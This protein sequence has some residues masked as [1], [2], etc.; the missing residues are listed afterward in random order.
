MAD[1]KK[2]DEKPA[3]NIKSNSPADFKGTDKDVDKSKDKNPD[4]DKGSQQPVPDKV[5]PTKP[6]AAEG[7]KTVEQ[8]KEGAP[9]E[10]PPAEKAAEKSGGEAPDQAPPPDT[11]APDPVPEAGSEATKDEAAG[12]PDDSTPSGSHKI[13]IEGEGQ[14]VIHVD[15]A[16]QYLDKGK[17]IKVDDATLAALDA[18]EIEYKKKGK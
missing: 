12:E 4:P 15:G 7:G 9:S 5:N 13:I 10:A 16:V 3:E 1:K 6:E 14:C 11:P 2:S 8:Q 18:A 17:P